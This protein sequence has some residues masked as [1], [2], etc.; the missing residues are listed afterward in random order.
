MKKV[1]G[2]K[3]TK[4]LI[5]FVKTLQRF[6]KK[7]FDFY[8]TLLI[9]VLIRVK[10]KRSISTKRDQSLIVAYGTRLDEV[11]KNRRCFYFS[12]NTQHDVSRIIESSGFHVADNK[13]TGLHGWKDVLP[14][15]DDRS[16]TRASE[17]MARETH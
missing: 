10:N 17:H 13:S 11:V 7:S 15:D 8:W 12:L 6:V 1:Q 14:E 5:K 16:T 2:T 4:I 3:E 9:R